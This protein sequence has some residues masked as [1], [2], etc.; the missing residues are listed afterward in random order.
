MVACIAWR[1]WL[2]ALSNK[3]YK[4]RRGQRNHEEIGALLVRPARQKH[5]KQPCYAVYIYGGPAVV[6]LWTSSCFTMWICWR[7]N[8]FSDKISVSLNY[9]EFHCF[10]SINTQ[11]RQRKF[12]LNLMMILPT[13]DILLG[14][15]TCSP[16]CIWNPQP[17]FTLTIHIAFWLLAFVWQTLDGWMIVPK[18]VG[19]PKAMNLWIIWAKSKISLLPIGKRKLP[20]YTLAW[21]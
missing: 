9:Q 8:L 2:G 5:T 7:Q 4:S 3:A 16:S 20:G 6:W 17:L 13:K 21:A 14:C 15:Y 10:L 19:Y 12:W 18:L 11:K 1:F